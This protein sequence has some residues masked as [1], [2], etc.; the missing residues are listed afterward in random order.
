MNLTR[1]GD[2]GLQVI[3]YWTFYWRPIKT[4]WE[5]GI[6]VGIKEIGGK[7]VKAVIFLK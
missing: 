2:V 7:V 3:L 4:L 5:A 1:E 6:A